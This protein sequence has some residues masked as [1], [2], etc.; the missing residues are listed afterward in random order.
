MINFSE[1]ALEGNIPNSITTLANLK[2]LRMNENNLTG[3]IP[4]GF[5]QLTNLLELWIFG[6]RLSGEL[7]YDFEQNP[8]YSRWGVDQNVM[9][10]QAGYSLTYP[11]NA[12]VSTDFSKDGEV[13]ELQKA[14]MG[15]GVNIVLLG[16][17]FV[18]TDM[19]EG[20]VYDQ[21]MNEALGYLFSLEPM[22]SYKEY[23]NI[24]FVRVVS[25]HNRFAE[26][27]ETALSSQL[28]VAPYVVGNDEKGFEYA[29]KVP[30]IN[31][32]NDLTI[33]V[34]L[35]SNIY[36][37]TTFWYENGAGVSY[38]GMAR[39]TDG[40]YEKTFESTLIHEVMGHAFAKL[41]DEYVYYNET[42]PNSGNIELRNEWLESGYY[43]NIDIVSNSTQIRW[44]HMLTDER[45]STYTGIVEGGET[46]AYGIWKPEVES[47]MNHNQPYF[48]APSREAIVKRIMKLAGEE[49]SFESFASKDRY[50]PLPKTRTNYVEKNVEQ[51]PTPVWVNKLKKSK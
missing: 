43:A 39:P 23:F 46:F 11:S 48:N 17:G 30:G 19:T 45:F 35:N 8:N 41:A 22:K 13:I 15:N 51:L 26:G 5:A 25:K 7:P 29:M 14:T 37:G 18:D 21:A 9:V 33:A 40:F 6:N 3:N 24:Y 44:A 50:V 32:T 4:I 12:Y 20:G 49:Y 10:Q 1:N 2:Y 38:V 36:A 47:M 34:V 27:Y 28:G 42:Y 31:S 16:D